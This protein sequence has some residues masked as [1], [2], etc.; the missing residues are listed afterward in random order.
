MTSDHNAPIGP[1]PR[2]ERVGPV[3]QT[4]A[5]EVRAWLVHEDADLLAFAKDG[6][7]PCHPAKDGPF[8]SLSSAVR[9][10]F[11]LPAAHL[12]FRLDRETSGLVVFA[13]HEAAARRLQKAAE[14][15]LYRKTYLTLLEGELNA[16]ATVNRPLGRD[17][18]SPVSAKNTVVAEGEG[19]P[20]ITHFQPLRRGADMTLAAVVTETGRKHQ[21]RAHAAWLGHPLIGDKIYGPDARLFLEFIERGWTPELKARL[22]LERQALH[23]AQIDLRPMGID[24]VLHSPWPADLAAFCRSDVGWAD[25]G[26][27]VQFQDTP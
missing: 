1:W 26:Q 24:L 3:H 2:I 10:V 5:A 15:K 23:C 13:K 8:S 9:E 4:T 6:H 7:L 25:G 20:A 19:Q 11:G 12:V 18:A 16:P 17:W 21:I 14:R 22:R 27:A